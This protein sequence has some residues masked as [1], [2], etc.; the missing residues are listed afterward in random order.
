M[1]QLAKIDD[2]SSLSFKS[3]KDGRRSESPKMP[4]PNPLNASP[5]L[6]KR[7]ENEVKARATRENKVEEDIRALEERENELCKEISTSV[8]KEPRN[9]KLPPKNVR[10]KRLEIKKLANPFPGRADRPKSAI[11]KSNGARAKLRMQRALEFEKRGLVMMRP[12]TASGG[13]GSR[14]SIR[15][16]M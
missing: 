3:M 4:S 2:E 5:I 12:S 14:T 7:A 10:T 1:S 13:E 6:L 11:G 15:T 8:M 16:G 9:G